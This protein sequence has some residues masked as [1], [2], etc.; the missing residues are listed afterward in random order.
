MNIQENK[1]NKRLGSQTTS[2]NSYN[3]N[4]ISIEAFRLRTISLNINLVKHKI[5][6][7]QYEYQVLGLSVG[8][9]QIHYITCLSVHYITK[10]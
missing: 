7:K 8:F 4:F 3:Q 5:Y 10:F 1:V 2:F 6:M 9:P